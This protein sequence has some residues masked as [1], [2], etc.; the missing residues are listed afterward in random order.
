M[1]TMIFSGRSD[2]RR[3]SSARRRHEQ[4]TRIFLLVAALLA[5]ASFFGGYA[6]QSKKTKL[7]TTASVERASADTPARAEALDHIDE[8][9]R[10]KYE[11][12]TAGALS[13]LDRA[14]RAD[15]QTP[16]LELLF[17]V[18]ALEQQE[19]SATVLAAKN[20]IKRG[21]NVAGANVLLGLEAWINRDPRALSAAFDRSAVFLRAASDL[22]PWDET[23]RSFM[24]DLLRGTG[25]ER[26]GYQLASEA[27][28]RTLPWTSADLLAAKV[29]FALREAGV[30]VAGG[31][32][33]LPDSP[34]VRGVSFIVLGD[35]GSDQPGLNPLLSLVS[36]CTVRAVLT[37][38]LAE[39]R[40]S[41][42]T[43]AGVLRFPKD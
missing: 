38:R 16:G 28:V 4:A 9:I 36:G 27:L 15:P 37:D 34:W 41:F 31:V 33:F 39:D 18:M 7:R 8:A 14:R 2:S 23:A 40:L 35:E 42:P 17:A 26:E 12:R 22:D 20:A 11:K 29:I 1:I 43:P 13:A 6:W 5:V 19:L 10:A 25:R 21:N 3:W 24:S 32:A 30:T